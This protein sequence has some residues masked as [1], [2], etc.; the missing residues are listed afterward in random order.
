MIDL[1]SSFV[2]VKLNNPLVIASSPLTESAPAILKCEE[3]G[4]GAVIAKSCSST[5]VGD[6]GFRRCLI[7]KQGWWAASTFDREIQ[8]V[9]E[10]VM[11]LKDSVS[12]CSIPIFASVSELTLTAERW[13]STCKEVQDTGV[14]GIQLDLFYFENVLGEADFSKKIVELLS[15][16]KDEIVIPIFPKL[17]I[18]LPALLMADLFKQAG[19]ECISLL[20]SISLPAPFSLVEECKPALRFATNISKASLFGRWQYPLTQKYLYELINK[21][22]IVCA[23]GGV[24]EPINIIELLMLG[25]SAVQIATAIILNGYHTIPIFIEGVRDY[26]LQHDLKKITDFQ[27]KALEHYQGTT[28]Y[29]NVNLLFDETKCIHCSKCLE[30]A[31][32]TAITNKDNSLIIDRQLCDGCSLC[33]DLCPSKALFIA[34]N[35]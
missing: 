24:H 31:F 3:Y 33:V 5:R 9:K 34:P 15:V 18:N 26:M 16:L 28:I 6:K 19:I 23:G 22:F 1:T 8:D 29:Q 7:D 27:G 4:A 2:G 17:N 35:E 25:A 20:D 10:V 13:I 32:C 12:K 30:Q 21:G 14:L 11:Y